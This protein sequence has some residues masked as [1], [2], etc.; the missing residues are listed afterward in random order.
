MELTLH[1]CLWQ[2]KHH[3]YIIILHAGMAPGFLVVKTEISTDKYKVIIK[4]MKR[5]KNEE[6]SNFLKKR[7]TVFLKIVNIIKDKE[8]V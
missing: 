6:C 7:R 8:R 4:K 3:V 5:L 2:A 1:C